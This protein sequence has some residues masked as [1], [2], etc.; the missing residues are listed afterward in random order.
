LLREIPASTDF[1][2]ARTAS[3]DELSCSARSLR[4]FVG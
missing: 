4:I 3:K 1:G 2:L